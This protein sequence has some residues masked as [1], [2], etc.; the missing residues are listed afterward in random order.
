LGQNARETMIDATQVAA[1]TS[2]RTPA[3]GRLGQNARE[4]MIDATQAAFG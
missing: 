2:G 1:N 4:T 3:A